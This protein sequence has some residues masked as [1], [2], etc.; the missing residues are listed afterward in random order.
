V[1]RPLGIGPSGQHV[2]KRS[3]MDKD[4]V[5]KILLEVME[6]YFKEDGKPFEDSG[7]LARLTI[8]DIK[9]KIISR[10]L[11]PGEEK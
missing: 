6:L 9:E 10:S 8:Q 11:C 3:V 1:E 2:N 4:Q 7:E 5:I